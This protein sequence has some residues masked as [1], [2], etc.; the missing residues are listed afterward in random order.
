MSSSSSSSKMAGDLSAISGTPQDG[1]ASFALPAIGLGLSSRG[2]CFSAMSCGGH[3][4]T[5]L[6]EDENEDEDVAT[7]TIDPA[8]G[9][10]N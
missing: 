7:Q 2:S 1:S 10:K 5:A 9:T 4:S 3:V 6:I 8:A